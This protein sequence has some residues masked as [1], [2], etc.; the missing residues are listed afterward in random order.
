MANIAGLVVRSAY[1][2]YGKRYKE[3][4]DLLLMAME[5]CESGN[6]NGGGGLDREFVGFYG[7]VVGRMVEIY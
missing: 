5:V 7:Q 4:I 6:G 2:A 3:A 1:E